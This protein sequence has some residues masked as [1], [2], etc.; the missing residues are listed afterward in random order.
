MQ[1]RT[2]HT[3]LSVNPETGELERRDLIVVTEVQ[4]GERCTLLSIDVSEA[5]EQ[6]DKAAT[7]SDPPAA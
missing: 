7:D 6:S 5:I 1:H 4:P 2:K 3:K